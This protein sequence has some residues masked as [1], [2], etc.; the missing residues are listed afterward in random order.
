[1]QLW[2]RAE[3]WMEDMCASKPSHGTVA[4]TPLALSH[5]LSGRGQ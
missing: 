5:R 3:V 4:L 1:M 2:G